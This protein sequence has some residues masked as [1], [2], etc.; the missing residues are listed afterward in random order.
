MKNKA[1]K[2]CFGDQGGTIL[3][4]ETPEKCFSCELFDR[5]HK[6]TIAASFQGIAMDL[7]MIVQNGL[8]QGW[9]KNFDELYEPPMDDLEDREN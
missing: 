1:I 2:E 5:C 3:G 8:T 7:S 6:V 4:G 9:L